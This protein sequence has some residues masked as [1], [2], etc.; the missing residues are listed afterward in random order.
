MHSKPLINLNYSLKTQSEP[1]TCIAPDYVMCHSSKYKEFLEK[2]AKYLKT[3]YGAEA[4]K[5]ADFGRIVSAGHCTRLQAMLEGS[6]RIVCGGKID[7]SDRFVEPTIVADVKLD[8]K[9]MAE[10]IF[11]PLLPVL[12][13]ENIDDVIKIINSE[14]LKK[15]LALYI[16][17]KDREM[18]DKVTSL[19]PS[20]GV[21]VNDTIFHVLNPYMP[22]GGV[23]GSGSGAYHGECIYTTLS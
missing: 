11:G 15:P 14:R 6:G 19:V 13:Y 7:V 1:Q 9:L 16:V 5:S 20:G 10:E 18:I 23:G 21:V 4:Q 12:Q 8:S 3:F 2:G 17:S 22:F